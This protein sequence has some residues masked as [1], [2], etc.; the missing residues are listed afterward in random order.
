MQV[1]LSTKPLEDDYAFSMAS[2][3]FSIFSILAPLACIVTITVVMS[4]LV[5]VNLAR[6]LKIR[7]QKRREGVKV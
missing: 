6:T 4:F 2:Y 5:I 3:V 1:G 7:G